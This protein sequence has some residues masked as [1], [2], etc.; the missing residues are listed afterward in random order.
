MWSDA[1]KS[2]NVPI[3]TASTPRLT[4]R[5]KAKAFSCCTAWQGGAGTSAA[6]QPAAA[7]AATPLP[8]KYALSLVLY[9]YC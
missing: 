5:D 1:A 9:R 8:Q 4:N 3:D 6:F 7:T 2:I